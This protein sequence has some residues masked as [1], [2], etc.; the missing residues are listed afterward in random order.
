M[1]IY[2]VEGL[3]AVYMH[4]SVCNKRFNPEPDSAC[5]GGEGVLGVL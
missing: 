4:V 3:E 5:C 2:C 1:Y